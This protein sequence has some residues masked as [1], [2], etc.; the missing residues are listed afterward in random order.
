LLLGVCSIVVGGCVAGFDADAQAYPEDKPFQGV[1]DV[2]VFR[3]ANW[4][5]FTNT[6]ARRYTQ[7]RIW[8]NASYSRPF[9]GL[10][11]GQTLR[12]NLNEFVDDYNRQFRGGGFFSAVKPS[13]LV[14][15]D[16]EDETGV[17]GLVIVRDSPE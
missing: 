5:E 8:A 1:V 12:L 14:R 15:V 6:S 13:A 17:Y 7:G 4:I 3:N 9:R 2:Q 10:R 11:I 16:I